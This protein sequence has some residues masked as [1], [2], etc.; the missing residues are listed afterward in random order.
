VRRNLNV[1]CSVA[2]IFLQAREVDFVPCSEL[3]IDT[4]ETFRNQSGTAS[5]FVDAAIITAARR[6]DARHIATFDREFADLKG[7]TVVR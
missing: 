4:L 1:A 3:F 2:S 5:S 6:C 7:I